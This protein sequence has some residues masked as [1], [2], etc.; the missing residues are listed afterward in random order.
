[1]MWLD[2]GGATRRRFS[3]KPEAKLLTFC[4]VRGQEPFIGP[5]RR[6]GTGLPN[7]QH[8]IPRH[9]PAKRKVRNRF[10][11]PYYPSI[12]YFTSPVSYPPPIYSTSNVC[13]P[14]VHPCP[15]PFAIHKRVQEQPLQRL[16]FVPHHPSSPKSPLS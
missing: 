12:F 11:S 5:A 1:M 3:A 14:T 16:F 8:P 7:G 6:A 2:E 10:R 15:H 9:S 13:L 4:L